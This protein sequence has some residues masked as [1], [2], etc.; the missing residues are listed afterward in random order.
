M[1]RML[2][3]HLPAPGQRIGLLGGSFN[4]AHEGHLAISEEA[5]RRLDL[6]E[7]W[8]LV[9]PQNPLKSASGMAPQEARAIRAA[10]LI[11]HPR[12]RATMLERELGTAYTAQS[13][14]LLVKRFP[15]VHFVWLMGADNLVQIDRWQDWHKIFN[16]MP[17]AIFDRPTYSLRALAA[18]AA[19]RFARY[20]KRES[21]SK[22]LADRRPPAWV[23][24]HNRL[25][26]QSSTAM[27]AAQ[28]RA[29]TSVRS[30]ICASDEGKD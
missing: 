8:W 30:A 4:P 17:I 25:N 15:R 29:T 2:G 14:R 10:A 6:D 28:E 18:I 3:G 11:R 7:I 24:L 20:R 22:H 27:R 23:F 1:G 13:L 9:S 16:T 12:I 5:L 21:E 26:A 19:R